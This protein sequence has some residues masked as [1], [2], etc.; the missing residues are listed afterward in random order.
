MPFT[1]TT[2]QQCTAG[3]YSK[4]STLSFDNWATCVSHSV[5][6]RGKAG[7]ADSYEPGTVVYARGSHPPQK[8]LPNQLRTDCY[9]NTYAGGTCNG[10]G[11]QTSRTVSLS[12]RRLGSPW[13][14]YATAHSFRTGWRVNGAYIDSGNS[15]GVNNV[16]SSLYLTLSVRGLARCK[17][18]DD[19][20]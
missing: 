15:T 3:S 6:R 11:S 12:G 18:I 14:Q 20:P 5:V 1:T 2:C 7:S 19:T 8:R 17:R 9:L 4:G 13:A 10:P 16:R